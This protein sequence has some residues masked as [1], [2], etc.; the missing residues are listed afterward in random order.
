MNYY[1]FRV[2]SFISVDFLDRE[3]IGGHLIH[4]IHVFGASVFF[5]FLYLH[6]SRGIYY[7]SYVLIRVWYRGIRILVISMGI[8]FLGYVL[9]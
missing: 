2:Y 5:L 6:I 3:I 9:P 4:V 8:A 7:G 1:S